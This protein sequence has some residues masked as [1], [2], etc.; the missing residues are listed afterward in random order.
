MGAR[1]LVNTLRTEA[2]STVQPVPKTQSDATSASKVRMRVMIS[3]VAEHGPFARLANGGRPGS[4]DVSSCR[5]VDAQAGAG[6]VAGG[7]ARDAPQHLPRIHRRA[8]RN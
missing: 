6:G 2:H 1:S 8:T 3:R 7:E 5:E 4:L